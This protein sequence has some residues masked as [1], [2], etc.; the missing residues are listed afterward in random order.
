MTYVISREIYYRVKRSENMARPGP[1]ESELEDRFFACV[2]GTGRGLSY[3]RL[4]DTYAE[5]IHRTSRTAKTHLKRLVE[6]ISAGRVRS[7][8]RY[9]GPEGW[10]Y[11]TPED[12]AFVQAKEDAERPPP[13]V[14]PQSLAGL[15]GVYQ[16]SPVN[17]NWESCPV[18]NRIVRATVITMG[19]ADFMECPLCNRAH[20][21]GVNP[22]MKNQRLY[23]WQVDPLV[24]ATEYADAITH[25]FMGDPKTLKPQP[26]RIA[27]VRKGGHYVGLWFRTS[28][29]YDPMAR[30]AELTRAGGKPKAG[31]KVR[32]VT[33]TAA[34]LP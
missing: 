11:G 24:N 32:P 15:G 8:A 10:L 22:K 28:W 14:R 3:G 30:L 2:K 34:C 23:A 13:V 5:R 9:K 18:K 27:R 29:D 7:V 4:V 26:P 19:V 17:S 1:T 20:F 6:G 12:E 25:G 16:D 21:L 33:A 31:R